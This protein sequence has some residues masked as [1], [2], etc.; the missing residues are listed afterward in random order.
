M[1]TDDQKRLLLGIA[2]DAVAAAVSGRRPPQVASDDPQLNEKCGA[3]VTLKS[4][5]RLRGCI[6]QFVADQPLLLTV[7]QMAVAAATQDPRFVADR[8]SP[9]EVADL[10]I[11]ISVLS[12]LKRTLDP[13]SLELGKHGIY[14]KRGLQSGCF[15]P[16]VATETGWSR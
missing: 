5:G 12:P 1:L 10:E 2:H 7:Q 14:I 16:Q 13:L 11:E 15:L 8:I 6:G 4:A 3:F 9:E